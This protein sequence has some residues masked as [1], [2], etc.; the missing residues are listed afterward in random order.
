MES[1]Q[2][3]RDKWRGL[4][5]QGNAGCSFD[6]ERLTPGRFCVAYSDAGGESMACCSSVVVVGFFDD[7]KDFLGFLRFAE[8][9]RV[10]DLD[11]DANR[12]P[13]PDVADAYI[14]KYE[15]EDRDRIDHL[16]GLIDRSLKAD[17]ISTPDLSVIHHA[18]N[19]AFEST[20]P[21]VQILAWG[22]LAEVLSSEHLEE[23]FEEAM[24]EEE[25][26]DENG[27]PGTMLKGLLDTGGF[28]ESNEEHLDLARGF[29]EQSVTV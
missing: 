14:L 7:A 22:S 17:M 28:D 29:L 4:L 12:D 10:L 2:A 18:F 15:G 23:D 27:R 20:N 6:L 16:L 11:T 5:E 19:Q 25:E 3:L 24:V 9:P 8:I 13:F 26:E 21:E 1:Y